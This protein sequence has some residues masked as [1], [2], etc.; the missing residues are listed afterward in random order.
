VGYLIFSTNITFAYYITS[1]LNNCE[2]YRISNF[3]RSFLT[4]VRRKGKIEGA[5]HFK[6]I[7]LT[8]ISTHVRTHQYQR[9]IKGR[10][11]RFSR[12]HSLFGRTL[13][14]LTGWKCT[15]SRCGYFLSKVWPHVQHQ[16]FI[17]LYGIET[18]FTAK[19]ILYMHLGGLIKFVDATSHI[20]NELV[21]FALNAFNLVHFRVSYEPGNSALKIE[22]W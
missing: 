4:K 3:I 9:I 6:W 8:S 19:T 12:L 22:T 15:T 17:I 5:S 7:I 1:H 18:T 11:W 13:C 10:C 21:L 20:I 16:A 14:M 2:I